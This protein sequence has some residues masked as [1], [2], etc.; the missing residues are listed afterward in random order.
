M[1]DQRSARSVGGNTLAQARDGFAASVPG[2]DS[3]LASI[4][5]GIIAVDN[6]WRIVYLNPAG[7][8][9]WGRTAR[10]IV[11]KT[12][13]EAL[14]IGADNPFRLVYATSKSH[15][16]PV[17]FS[18]Y[19]EIFGAWVEV[20][21]YPH[22]GGYTIL[23]RP[24][25]EEHGRAGIIQESERERTTIRSI[26]QRI[27]D[28]SLD[29]ILVVSKRGDFV[30]VSPS[31]H[32]ILGRAPDDMVGRSA[33]DFVLPEDL[34]NTRNEMRRARRGAL[35]RTFE[36]RYLHKDGHPV[37]I[38]WTGIWSEPDGQY[39]FIG[40]DVTDRIALENQLRQAQKMEAIGQLT[41]G[42]AHDFN[43]LLTVI[44]GMSELLSDSVGQDPELAPI[45]QAIDEAASRGAQLTQRMLAFAR[46]QPLQARNVDLNEVVARTA[47]ILQRTLGEDIAVKLSPGEGLWPA[48][49]DPSQIEDV[50]LNLAVNARDAM[51]NGG[52]LVIETANTHLDE[53][54]AAQNVEVAAGDYVLVNVTDSGT[55]MPPDVVERVFEPFFT[56]KEVGRGTGLGLSMVYGFVKQ[57]RGH[58]KIYSEVGHGT[59]IKLYLPRARVMAQAVEE[60][61]GR[62]AAAPGGSETLLVVED[63]PTVRG[64]AVSML[65]GLGYTVLEAADGHAALAILETRVP[66]DLL[67]TDLI[68]P[69]GINGQDL[70]RRGRALRPDL[71]A[72]FT[73]GYSEQFLR[74]R[75]SA[76]AG[77]P[78]L[79]KP[80]RRHALAEA[81]RSVLDSPLTGPD[82]AR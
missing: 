17:S 61:D 78:L 26:N 62:V 38:A 23:F 70:L 27:F 52:Q 69:N 7:E 16:E 75:N 51:P 81:V 48:L 36:C 25:N 3:V 71:R 40:R 42:V 68:M 57:S 55:G 29:L 20:R 35:S 50:I 47:A 2:A 72:M 82:S 76:D 53:Q 30:R 64:I 6:D 45:V 4:S 31:S 32:A 18:G 33:T 10:T 56:T 44:I 80:Y 46:K 59:S 66:I 74:D 73:S 9:L 60:A 39:F 79:N 21:G 41:G 49:V 58:V 12:I 1:N 11:G 14:D 65:R 37:P 22:P 77:V 24:A 8:R 15:N 5:D 28:T 43:N 34:E 67:F 13:H 63:S 54:Y 19:S